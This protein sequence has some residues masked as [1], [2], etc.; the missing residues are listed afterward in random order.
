MRERS[1]ERYS[2][3]IQILR[4]INLIR[5]SGDVG[6]ESARASPLCVTQWRIAKM[7]VTRTEVGV[8]RHSGSDW[9]VAIM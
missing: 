7:A 4:N 6:V 9:W 5:M 2:E 8:T 1:A 3:S